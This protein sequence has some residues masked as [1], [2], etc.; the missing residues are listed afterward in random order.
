VDPNR[1]VETIQVVMEDRLLRRV[2][3][4][5]RRLRVSRSALVREALRQHLGDLPAAEREEAD[6]RGYERIPDEAEDLSARNRVL[7]WPKD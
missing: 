1:H 7:M 2:D 5:A 4:A 3:Q 6:P